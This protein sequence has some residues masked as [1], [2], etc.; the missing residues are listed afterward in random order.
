MAVAELMETMRSPW[1][2]ARSAWRGCSPER[3]RRPPASP[4]MPGCR[5]GARVGRGAVELAGHGAG[6]LAAR[7]GQVGQGV[8][9]G[10]LH[11]ADLRERQ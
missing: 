4:W 3:C 10:E 5:S 8:G 6:R 9:H 1:T 11:L 2:P 7:E